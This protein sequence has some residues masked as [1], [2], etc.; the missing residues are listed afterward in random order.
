MRE[1]EKNA[2][3]PLIQTEFAH[4]C[5][6]GFNDFEDRYRRMR[7]RPDVWM[8]GCVWAWIDQS[9]MHPDSGEAFEKELSLTRT[10]GKNGDLPKDMRRD[11]PREFQGN[12]IDARHFID[13]WGDR[14]TDGIVYGD[15]TPKDGYWLVRA[16]YRGTNAGES[17]KF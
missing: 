6:N 9:I 16:R 1:Y 10:V 13:S 14:A 12:Y 8:G 17:S 7:E 11:M 3:K 2:T 5:G 4:A 15:G